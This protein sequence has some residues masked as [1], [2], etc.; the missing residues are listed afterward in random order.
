M[1]D[2]LVPASIPLIAPDLAFATL[3]GG[4]LCAETADTEYTFHGDGGRALAR[5]A[6]RLDGSASIADLASEAGVSPESLAKVMGSLAEDGLLLDA[7]RLLRPSSAE[8]FLTAYHQVC[9]LWS[10]ELR[11]V[12]F[13]STLASGRAPRSLVLGWGVEFY[14]YVEAANEHMAASVAYCR[15]DP[16]ARRWF[17]E[18]YAQEYNHSTIFL[19]GLVACGLD[20]EQVRN[21]PPLST[22]RALVNHLVELAT[23]DH[24]A[25]AGAF[26]MMRDSKA[27]RDGKGMRAEQLADLYGF[28][29]GYFEAIRKHASLDEDLKHDDLVLERIVQRDGQV[30]PEV[31]RRIAGG[32]RS[33]LE[34]FVLFF[35]GIQDAYGAPSAQVPRRAVDVRAL[36]AP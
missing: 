1:A 7:R 29:R 22:T 25:Y 32:A 31:A 5:V 8:E 4:D 3:P 13:W 30:A 21:A 34:H 35:E 12:P 18:H 26:G 24:L 19:E 6:D 16:T 33:M 15:T 11:L 20:R 17:A 2:T 27:T 14:H 9:D 23:T 28:A 36:S 10:R